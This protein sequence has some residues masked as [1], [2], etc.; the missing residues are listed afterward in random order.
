MFMPGPFVKVD[1]PSVSP[2]KHYIVFSTKS[3]PAV[4]RIPWPNY[5]EEDEEVD[6]ENPTPKR[7]TQHDTWV[8]DDHELPWLVDP[9]GT[10]P[11]FVAYM[12]SLTNI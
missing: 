1:V 3:P 7:F 10:P 12:R 4:Q 6:V 11:D 9:D 2:R 8:I 5:D